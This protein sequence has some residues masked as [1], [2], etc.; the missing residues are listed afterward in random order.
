[1]ERRIIL[2]WGVAL[3]IGVGMFLL[4]RSVASRTAEVRRKIQALS[5][6][7]TAAQA[8]LRKLRASE[9][10]RN[11]VS[12][13]KDEPPAPVSP[14]AEALNQRAAARRILLASWCDRQY[15][16]FFRQAGLSLEQIEAFRQAV[17][18][19]WL[20]W[21]ETVDVIR[22]Q[23]LASNDP[24]VKKLGTEEWARFAEETK[25][26]LGP[27][28]SEQLK[29][30]SRAAPAKPVADTVGALVFDSGEPLRLDQ[31]A[32]VTAALANS[33]ARFRNGGPVS[34]DDVDIPSVLTQLQGTLTPTQLDALR[35][36]LTARQ[37]G[38]RLNTLLTAAQHEKRTQVSATSSPDKGAAR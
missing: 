6:T 32:T 10:V 5:A 1:M 18:S 14:E 38:S 13:P 16:P 23:G 2:G 11:V 35:V 20:R 22:Q 26:A 4:S 30:F 24:A 33:S 7:Q 17:L 31:S 9:V 15:R 19:H 27:V 3:M 25:A 12:T 8:E 28:A 21:C 34:L 36:S 37:A 29:Q